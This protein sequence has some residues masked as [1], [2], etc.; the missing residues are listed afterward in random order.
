MVSHNGAGRQGFDDA[1]VRYQAVAATA[2]ADAAQNPCESLQ[3]GNLLFNVGQMASRDPV[4]FGTL[5]ILLR[6]QPEQFAHLM[7]RES[8]VAAAPD[9]PQAA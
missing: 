1:A 6:R 9:E 3:V 5:L 2:T 4:H 8:Q 7:E